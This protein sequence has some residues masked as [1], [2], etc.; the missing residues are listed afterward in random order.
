MHHTRVGSSLCEILLALV[1]LST[2]AAWALQATATAE[3]TLGRTANTRHALH[4]AERSLADLDALPCDSASFAS[5]TIE[6]RWQLAVR[7]ASAG[8]IHH[9]DVRLRF[10]RGDSLVLH[11]D[12]WCE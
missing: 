7:R 2:T 5:T 3:R 8:N 9:D 10:T 11:H 4:R 1:L 12:G 6:P